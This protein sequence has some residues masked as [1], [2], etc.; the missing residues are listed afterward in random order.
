[1]TNGSNSMEGK[2]IESIKIEGLDELAQQC[3]ELGFDL[4]YK[5]GL[6]KDIPIVGMVVS[7]AKAI[8]SFRDFLYLKKLLYFLK[9]VGEA[10]QEE[11]ER[12][13]E[14]NCK[15]KKQFEEAVLLILEQTDSM[16]KSSLIGKI[17]K[18]CMQGKITYEEALKLS[19]MVNRAYWSDLQVLLSESKVKISDINQSL[20]ASGLYHISGASGGGG[21]GIFGGGSIFGGGGGSSVR[22]K[23]TR[24][25]E[26]LIEISK[27]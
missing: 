23:I 7:T 4:I 21:S 19:D 6:L 3:S 9:N 24:F 27:I 18:A 11:R 14:E 10:T 22:H 16:N 5:E 12:F 2:L 17:F 15:N 8:G 20:L 1:M 13:I 25:G 26:K